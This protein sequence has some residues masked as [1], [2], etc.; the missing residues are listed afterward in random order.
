[1]PTFPDLLYI[2]LDNQLQ[3][4]SDSIDFDSDSNLLE[5]ISPISVCHSA[6]AYFY[7]P[8]DPSGI[9]GMR[10]EHIRSTPSWRSAGPHHDDCVFVVEKQNERSFVPPHF[11]HSWSLDS[12]KAF[13]VNKY[14]D[15]HFQ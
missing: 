13:F 7:A 11:D 14:A 1:M 15:H 10:R 3:G 6:M 2:F 8:S 12:S 4:E 9:R 5:A